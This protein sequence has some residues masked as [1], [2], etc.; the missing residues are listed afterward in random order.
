M[1]SMWY[2]VA[3]AE[4]AIRTPQVGRSIR[5]K[6]PAAAQMLDEWRVCVTLAGPNQPRLES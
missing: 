5:S 1:A 4:V 2:L 6:N 3:F